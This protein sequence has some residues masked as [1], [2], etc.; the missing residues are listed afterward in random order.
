MRKYLITARATILESY[1]LEA[2]S[3]EDAIERWHNDEG[4]Y[5]GRAD[6]Y[7]EPPEIADVKPRVGRGGKEA[8]AERLEADR[9]AFRPEGGEAPPPDRR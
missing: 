9:R 6:A 8:H 4:E 3:S 7:L 2:A 5:L 1:E